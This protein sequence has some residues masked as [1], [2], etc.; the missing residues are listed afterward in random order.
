[1]SWA[2]RD[3]IDDKALGWINYIILSAQ[4][5]LSIWNF[6]SYEMEGPVDLCGFH[7][8]GDEDEDE[9]V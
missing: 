5:L 9:A 6:F 3:P 4:S 1:M 2:E 7:E 8:D